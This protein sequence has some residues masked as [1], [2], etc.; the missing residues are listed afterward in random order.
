MTLE[1][2]DSELA[3]TA[4]AGV[5][6]VDMLDNGSI[7]RELK[8]RH[9]QMIALGGCVGT[10]LFVGTG[11]SLAL[12]GPALLLIAFIVMSFLVYLIVTAVVEVVAYLPV[13]GA[14]MSYYGTRYVSKSLGFAMGWLYVYSLGILVPYE[15]TA[16]A[17]V[18]DYWD[19]PVNVAVWITIFMVFIIGLNFLPVSYYGESEFWFSSIKVL[20][21]AGLLI[22]SFILFWGGGPKQDGILG[23]HYWKDPGAIHTYLADGDTG[24]FVAFVQ[25]LVLSA[26]PY[27]FSPELLIATSGEMRNPQKDLHKAA[28]RFILR[29]LVFYIGTV[30]AIGVICPSDAEDLSS[31]GTNAKSSAFVV[32][33]KTAG[34]HSLG[35][36]VNA[37]ILTIAWSAGNA[38]LYMSSRALYALAI[39]GQAPKVFLR[40][41]ER[42]VPYAAVMACSLF[43]LLSYL[44]CAS[45]SSTVFT[46]FVTITNTSAFISWICCC[47]V[48]LRFRAAYNR[49]DPETRPE[50]PYTSWTQPYGAWFGLFFFTVLMLINGF[51]VFF[52]GQLTPSSFFTAYIGIP[53]F[54]V[55]YLGHKFIKGRKDPLWFAAEDIDIRE[56][57]ENIQY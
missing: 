47:V 35:S 25:T 33:I 48:Y 21:I 16:G 4:S 5:A 39:S 55:I 17:L 46:W 6:S 29:L 3:R 15:I 26:F 37:S 20:T 41:T 44:N 8:P 18:I 14:S 23:F 2:K 52:P 57:L 43:G 7:K 28:N 49:Q 31:G 9:S 36:V 22:L 10:G 13:G 42:G 56:G 27:T 51:T 12:G 1:K 30:I 34:I 54:V 19:S 38:Y 24:R 32:G 11:A 40:C 50:L 45:S 53:A